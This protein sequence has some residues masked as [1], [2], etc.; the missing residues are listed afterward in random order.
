MDEL[1][2]QGKKRVSWSMVKNDDGDLRMGGYQDSIIN[3]HEVR[4]IRP[5]RCVT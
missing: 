4:F 1:G 5:S 2:N 3:A